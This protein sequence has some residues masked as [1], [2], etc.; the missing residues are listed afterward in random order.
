LTQADR[1]S[2][3]PPQRHLDL[4][5]EHMYAVMNR[6]PFATVI[7]VGDGAP[8]VSQLPLI[9]DRNR[10]EH[11]VLFGHVDRNNPQVRLLDGGAATIIF[12]GPNSYISPYTYESSQLP[13]WN[14]ISVYVT[15]RVTLIDDHERLIRGL[16]SICEAADPGP[17]AYRLPADR[18][19]H[20]LHR[21]VRGR[22][23]EHGR[24]LQ[25]FS[26]PG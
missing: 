3:Y 13:T 4:D 11:G 17:A 20:R 25:A 2:S 26:G 9:L 8:V 23:R 10:G 7:S 14:S 1:P 6:L 15:G 24:P 12:H 18:G 21:R 5:V 22:D 16:Q 19:P